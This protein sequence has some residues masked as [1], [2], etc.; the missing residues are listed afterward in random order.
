MSS[1]QEWKKWFFI[2]HSCIPHL[3][4]YGLFAKRRIKQ[5]AILPGQY[6]GVYVESKDYNDLVEK[7]REAAT[8]SPY[9]TK[10]GA[11]GPYG[12]KSSRED[13]NLIKWIWRHYGVEILNHED[14]VDWEAVHNGITWYAFQCELEE[15]AVVVT[16]L[17][18]Y[19][20][21]GHPVVD[22]KS[23]R[24]PYIFM[25]EPPSVREFH[26]HFLG[27][28]QKSQV[29]VIPVPPSDLNHKYK[30]PAMCFQALQDIEAGEE[31]FICYG[32]LYDRKYTINMSPTCGCGEF[33]QIQGHL[34]SKVNSRR[35]YLRHLRRQGKITADL[36]NKEALQDD[37]V[38]EYLEGVCRPP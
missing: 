27:R 12:A 7:L 31:L 15:G 5:G 29:N 14:G 17:P 25:N 32:A 35:S 3:K 9:G 33:D 23:T 22:K 11:R 18:R 21:D 1:S 8:E 36:L 28:A 2:D 34:N 16:L 13:K 24:N 10:G 20:H 4:G 38:I 6:H 19:S 26:N 30:E 37:R